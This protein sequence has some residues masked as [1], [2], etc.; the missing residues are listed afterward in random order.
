MNRIRT[1]LLAPLI[2]MVCMAV[3]YAWF[4]WLPQSI[5]FSV[6]QSKYHLSK[7][8]ESVGEGLVPLLLQN[9]LS[10]IYDNLALVEE[11]NPDWVYLSLSDK[12]QQSIYPFEEKSI[13]SDALHIHFLTHDITV[14]GQN[15]G[16]LTLVYDFSRIAETIERNAVNLF[17]LI[18][19]LMTAF[20]VIIGGVMHKFVLRPSTKLAHAADR[21]AKGDYETALPREQN[22]EIGV[23]VQ[24]FGKMRDK[25][26]N[27][28]GELTGALEKAEAANEAKSNFL[29]NMSHELRT[30][31]NGIIGLSKMALDTP[32]N[33]EQKESLGA[34]YNSS[35]S[36][37]VLLNDILDFSKIEANELVL[38]DIPFNLKHMLR[39]TM[40][41]MEPL[42]ARKEIDLSFHYSPAAPKYVVGDPARIRQIALNLV[43]NAIKFTE[44]G[45][46]SLD[47]SAI[48]KKGETV[49]LMRVDDTGIGI[50]EEKLSVIFNKFTQADESTSRK[51]GGTG[52]GLSI[53][54]SLSEMM[55]GGI[56]VH[57][58][59]GQGSSFR[60]SIAL[61]IA[62]ENDVLFM[63][64]QEEEQEG[65]SYD[66]SPYHILVVDDHPVNLTF[67]KK[68]AKK[69]GF[70]K[71]EAAF[72][73]AL[74]VEAVTKHDIDLILMDCQ[75]PEMDGFEATEKIREL[76]Q[77]MGRH[78]P[79]VA[80]TANALEGDRE[81]CLAAG[82]DDYI[83]KP[84]N[85]EKLSTILNKWL[86]PSI[87]PNDA[88]I[89]SEKSVDIEAGIT[90]EHKDQD[91]AKDGRQLINFDHLN[92]FT[93]GELEEEENLLEIFSETGNE[94]LSDLATHLEPEQSEVWRKAAH[95]I[96]GAAGTLGA[97]R[98]Y[99][100]CFLAERDFEAPQEDKQ[101]MLT[102]I[103]N[104]FRDVT[105]FF[106]E[107]FK[108][109]A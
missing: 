91:G 84:V 92:E 47:V 52:L 68:L 56:K 36:L 70:E 10:N 98:L 87:V 11:N 37:L 108:K 19:G 57:S 100:A 41:L 76:E 77:S 12:E 78:I 95:K 4:F 38:E 27:T 22:D 29:A 107:R 75:M 80:M 97:E 26:R 53:T 51:F 44:K 73:G 16:Q 49:F 71:I 14:E 69:M 79:I 43:G 33:D 30:P 83:S 1:K 72:N 25:I 74:A 21:L 58:I 62:S 106:Q 90:A 39:D 13:S 24:S 99:D 67:A 81:R 8:L 88:S 46:V 6:D 54:K 64:E 31:M 50:S 109:K 34:I 105:E 104:G 85:V 35:E 94:S 32:L 28:T 42:V 40:S 45:S 7:T 20:G 17:L 101:K 23:L 93:D 89:P 61:K 82:M 60:A 2:V 48:Q 9:Q 103:Q 59:E 5:K 18:L 102:D 65:K 66:F 15:L 3:G 86:K 55:C 96:K 63:S